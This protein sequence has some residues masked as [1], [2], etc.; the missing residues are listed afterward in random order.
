MLSY[1]DGIVQD[2]GV[3]SSSASYGSPLSRNWWVLDRYSTKGLQIENA[4]K[5]L[6]VID[7]VETTAKSEKTPFYP[8]QCLLQF[9]H[10]NTKDDDFGHKRSI[11]F[12]ASKQC[13]SR[14]SGDRV[15]K[16]FDISYVS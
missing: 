7:A 15:C 16:S 12:G 2:G 8:E 6:R 1:T 13:L 10:R 11:W 14:F 9:C 3:S 4:K 5:V